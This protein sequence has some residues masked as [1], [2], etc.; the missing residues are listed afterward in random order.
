MDVMNYFSA[1]R[2]TSQESAVFYKKSTKAIQPLSIQ[3][4]LWVICKLQ[5][6]IGEIGLKFTSVQ[7]LQLWFTIMQLVLDVSNWCHAPN[8]ISKNIQWTNKLS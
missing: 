6:Y 4:R 7:L 1:T 5:V 8:L 2:F 3:D